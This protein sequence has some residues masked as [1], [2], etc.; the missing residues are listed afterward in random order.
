MFGLGGAVELATGGGE[1]LPLWEGVSD[2]EVIP[3]TGWD[4]QVGGGGVV[5]S[6]MG[7]IVG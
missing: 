2:L 7:V 6:V 5:D 4:W 3:V 1:V